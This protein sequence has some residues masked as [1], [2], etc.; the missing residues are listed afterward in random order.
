VAFACCDSRHRGYF[1]ETSS[2]AACVEYQEEPCLREVEEV[3]AAGAG[4][5]VL[6]HD[7]AESTLARLA[8]AESACDVGY[9][10]L[11]RLLSPR[12]VL[13]GTAPNGRECRLN[14]ELPFCQEVCTG[15]QEEGY[16]CDEGEDENGPCRFAS[17]G[18]RY[19]CAAGLVCHYQTS[20]WI[21]GPPRDEGQAC[22][23]DSSCLSLSCLGGVCAAPDA[24]FTPR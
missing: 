5:V 2:E 21:C 20:G 24:C 7:L 12:I 16:V 10:E 22:S 6:D 19:G 13:A 14:N 17:G 18:I 11:L 23:W 9:N 1:G 8:S 4:S 3:V 15:D